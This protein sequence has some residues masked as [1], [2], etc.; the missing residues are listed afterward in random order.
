[1]FIIYFKFLEFNH[2]FIKI[3]K[4]IFLNIYNKNKILNV[5]F[6]FNRSL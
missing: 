4:F 3:K 6:L 5:K 2:L 1:M